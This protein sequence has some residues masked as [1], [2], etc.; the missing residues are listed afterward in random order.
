MKMPSSFRVPVNQGFSIFSQFQY[1]RFPVKG[2]QRQGVFRLPLKMDQGPY[3]MIPLKM[4][5]PP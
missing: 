3:S 4:K 2:K 1:T 5:L